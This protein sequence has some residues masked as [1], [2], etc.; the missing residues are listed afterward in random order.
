MKKRK[1]AKTLLRI[2]L[3]LSLS[4]F[5][6]ALLF[7]HYK[8]SRFFLLLSIFFFINFFVPF[9]SPCRSP[10]SPKKKKSSRLI[11]MMRPPKGK[12]KKPKLNR[13][14]KPLNAQTATKRARTPQRPQHHY[15]KKASHVLGAKKGRREEEGWRCGC[16]GVKKKN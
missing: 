5:L 3:S 9:P 15:T 8:C 6:C 16:A 4:L 7:V 2:L 11:S 1:T 14:K 13:Y 10:P 12:K